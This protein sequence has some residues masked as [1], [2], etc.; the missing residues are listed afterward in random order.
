MKW[1]V[2]GAAG[3]IGTNLCKYLKEQGATV[4]AIDDFS[5]DGVLSNATFLNSIGVQV[6][7]VDVSD[8]I[9]L[10]AY[11]SDSRFD[12]IAHLAGQVS[13]LQSITDPRRDFEVNVLGTFNILEYVRLKSP[14]A[15]LIGMSSN[16]IYGDL[17]SVEVLEQ[18][19]R[20]YAP[21]FPNGFDESLPL[22]FHGPYG[23]SK[24]AADQ[25][26]ADYSRIFGLKSASLRQSSVYGPFQH[27]R[28]DQGWVAFLTA[29]IVKGE[30][31]QLNGVGKQVR[32]L[33]HAGDL[34]RL[35]VRLSEV[36]K[37]GGDNQFNVGGGPDNAISILELFSL[38]E[39][40][41]GCR[42]SYSTGALR[43]SDQMIFISNN[44]KV[45]QL[46][47]WTPTVSYKQGIAA[48]V[49]LEMDSL[50]S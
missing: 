14:D 33:L 28:A 2:T 6:D 10:E 48:L 22:S 34:A 9:A 43:P 12:S 18:D 31:I 32:D 19:V 4:V 16:K 45:H 11:L 1:L 15:A 47:G 37:P 50:K 30:H 41:Y 7:K 13:L 44:K 38:I 35:I 23:C 20:Y 26:L 46:T 39:E 8:K 49:E 25:Y 3:F 17:Q 42:A 27:P 40:N 21:S 36:L 5:R 29:A 24:G